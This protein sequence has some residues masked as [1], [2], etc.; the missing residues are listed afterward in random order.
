MESWPGSAHSSGSEVLL[1]HL[2]A[3]TAQTCNLEDSEW[4]VSSI[5]PKYLRS[6]CC[7]TIWHLTVQWFF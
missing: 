2:V 1:K 5:P 7:L 6:S 3:Q 4:G